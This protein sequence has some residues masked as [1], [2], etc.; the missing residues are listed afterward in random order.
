MELVEPSQQM[1]SQ[2]IK[3]ALFIRGADV[4]VHT[5]WA[6]IQTK[7]QYHCWYL[8]EFT[9]MK[10]NPQKVRKALKELTK[11]GY[12]REIKAYPVFWEMVV[13]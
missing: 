10:I 12:L 5:L 8:N 2:E 11:K 6:R 4:V 9:D 13:K 1:V 3:T 7:D